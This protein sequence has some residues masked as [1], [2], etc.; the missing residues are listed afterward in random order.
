MGSL[1]LQLG[2]HLAAQSRQP[3]IPNNFKVI[4]WPCFQKKHLVVLC[5]F[6][7]VTPKIFCLYIDWLSLMNIEKIGF[8]KEN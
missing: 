1:G 8:R 6:L 7:Q 3:R 2:G 5:G 4:V